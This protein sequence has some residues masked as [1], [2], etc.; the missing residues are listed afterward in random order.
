[1]VWVCCVGIKD[2]V[3]KEAPDAVATCQRAG[4]VFRIHINY[5][6]QV[7]GDHLETAKHIA[8]EYGI[9][10]F[11]DD[12]CMTGGEFRELSDDINRKYYQN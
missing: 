10:T 8:K 4:I 3:R 1:M 5:G 9:V 7:T 6:Y 12:V 2:L 11:S